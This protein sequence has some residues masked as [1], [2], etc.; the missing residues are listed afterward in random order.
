MTPVMI[1]REAQADGVKLSLSPQGN[2]KAAGDSV[3]VNRWQ[4]LIRE[5]K[6]EIIEVLKAGTGDIAGTSRGWLIRFLNG[7]A[8]QV[9]CVPDMTEAA[10][11]AAYPDAMAA[12]PFMP[13]V[14]E[15]SNPMSA[16]EESAIREWLAL[17]DETDPATIAFVLHE[18]QRDDDAR[19][20]FLRRA[21]TAHFNSPFLSD[22]LGEKEV[23]FKQ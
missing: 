14:R 8:L 21:K 16:F 6:A 18:C 12:V 13:S 20:Y 17:I 1:I 9:T 15:P 3:V 22:Y 2:I 19:N 7:D 4:A 10:I 23:P 11:L 5:H